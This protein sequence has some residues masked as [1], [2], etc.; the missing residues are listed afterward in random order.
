MHWGVYSRENAPEKSTLNNVFI[1]SDLLCF[2]GKPCMVDMASGT[3]QTDHDSEEECRYLET[4]SAPL[5]RIL[6][7]TRDNLHALSLMVFPYPYRQ[8]S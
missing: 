2:T 8:N 7:A 6:I 1:G 3:I 5:S 4:N